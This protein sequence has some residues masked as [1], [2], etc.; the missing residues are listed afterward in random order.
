MSW[1]PWSGNA[2][3]AL[4][5]AGH[6]TAW[7]LQSG[8]LHT[9]RPLPTQPAHLLLPA[10]AASGPG[11]AGKGVG[12][13]SNGA[14][15]CGRVADLTR[16]RPTPTQSEHRRRCWMQVG[17]KGSQG[18]ACCPH[19]VCIHERPA[20]APLLP[21]LERLGIVRPRLRLRVG[22]RVGQVWSA[23]S[24]IWMAPAAQMD[25]HQAASLAC[26]AFANA[27]PWACGKACMRQL[28]HQ[29]PA[30][31]PLGQS[32]KKFSSAHLVGDAALE[33]NLVAVL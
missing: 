13:F 26:M 25:G 19:H 16:H 12:R 20:G 4:S 17:S 21:A 1:R 6:A 29:H 18:A 31:L 7:P 2:H 22:Q 33:E 28:R 9:G 5:W 32:A 8:S 15:Q 3:A 10:R 14:S 27:L 11:Q 23:S 24:G 30:A